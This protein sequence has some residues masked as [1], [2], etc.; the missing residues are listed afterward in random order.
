MILER[1]APTPVS[2]DP[3][4]PLARE[5]LDPRQH[6][7]G[8]PPLAPADYV[9]YERHA[10]FHDV[11]L[12]PDGRAIE[13]VGPALANLGRHVLP[14]EA[15]LAGFDGRTGR[16]VGAGA[17]APLAHR[18]R[19]RDRVSLHRFALPR[20]LHGR[21]ALEL[22]LAFANGL[23][24]ELAV[25]AGPADRAPAPALQVTTIQKDNPI[26]WIADWLR[27]LGLVGVDR[28]LLYDNGSAEAT[29][30]PARLGE[31]LAAVPPPG[32]LPAVTLVDWPYPYGPPRSYYNRFAQPTQNNHAHRR[33]GTAAWTG[34]FDVDE[35]P[36]V[37]ADPVAAGSLARWV[38][39]A[40][41]RTAL[42]RLDSH[43]A[44][45]VRDPDP[46]RGRP[47]VHALDHR[48]R[49]SRGRAHKYLVR[50]RA[51]RYANTHNARLRL[52]WAWRHPPVAEAC[53]LHYKPLTT[54]WR[55]FAARGAPEP[56]DPARHVEDRR[57]IEGLAGGAPAG[58]AQRP[59]ST[60]R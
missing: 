40:G 51:L 57:V 22:R 59:A 25:R 32:P 36:L 28:V 16:P 9:D 31:A 29:T 48:E 44:V 15:T 21:E 20:A 34:H 23:A 18:T 41:P 42:L 10:L 3:D 35:Y 27:W 46:A 38:G 58:A 37:G 2:L 1:V 17:G 43:W 53:Y 56:F 24:V 19:R 13:A 4:G 47:S 45:D 6:L 11:F 54:E 26:E 30:L 5:F 60:S 7:P 55:D 33:F 50:S 8:R 12:A 39:R 52:G 49:S 14:I